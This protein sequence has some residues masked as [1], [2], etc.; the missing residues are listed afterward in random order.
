M[1]QNIKFNTVTLLGYEQSVSGK[2]FC[3][4]LGRKIGDVPVG[5]GPV[6]RAMIS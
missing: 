3:P 4:N 5:F 6:D 2:P 1:N